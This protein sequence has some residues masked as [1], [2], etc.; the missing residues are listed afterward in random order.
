VYDDDGQV[1]ALV[2]GPKRGGA[3]F[4]EGD[5]HLLQRVTRE[6]GAL[7]HACRQQEEESRALAA[8]AASY[9][10]QDRALQRNAEQM[11]AGREKSPAPGVVEVPDQDANLAEATQQIV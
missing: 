11:L 1:A 8:L 10:Q 4:S 5:L 3:P 7:I 9:R 6:L 2:L